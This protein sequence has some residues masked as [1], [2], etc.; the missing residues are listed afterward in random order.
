MREAERVG[1]LAVD[2]A[3]AI[4]ELRNAL[5]RWLEY[6]SQERIA[7]ISHG[8]VTL[9]RRTSETNWTRA[10]E[11]PTNRLLPA[12]LHMLRIVAAQDFLEGLARPEG[13]L[14]ECLALVA[15]HTSTSGSPAGT[16][17]SPTSIPRSRSRRASAS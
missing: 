7:A 14:D 11:L 17:N 13:L 10:E 12:S 6:F 4:E 15:D 16:A 5:D 8:A 1:P 3:E 9:R 2:D